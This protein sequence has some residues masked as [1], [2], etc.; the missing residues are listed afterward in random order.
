MNIEKAIY[1]GSQLLKKN[2]IS[3]FQLDSEIL[4]SK[5]IKKD[6]NINDKLVNEAINIP[7]KK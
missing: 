5:V 1:E 6:R 7:P 3:S 2:D 4:M